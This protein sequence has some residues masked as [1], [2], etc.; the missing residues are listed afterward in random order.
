MQLGREIELD[1]HIMMTRSSGRLRRVLPLRPGVSQGEADHDQRT[2]RVLVPHVAPTFGRAR[3]IVP[4]RCSSVDSLA[5][6][7]PCAHSLRGTSDQYI[8]F[9][10]RLTEAAATSTTLALRQLKAKR[11]EVVNAIYADPD[12]NSH[13]TIQLKHGTV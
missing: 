11:S 7:S 2:V 13:V 12:A 9:S 1:Q 10:D 5:G 4:Q 8:A 6:L 3:S